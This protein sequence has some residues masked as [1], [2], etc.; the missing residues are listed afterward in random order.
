MGNYNAATMKL[1]R[2]APSAAVKQKRLATLLGGRSPDGEPR[3]WA[4]V[5][6]AQLLGSLQLAGFDF[7]WEQVLA[8]RR[9]E[10]VPAAL[11]DLRRAHAAVP[12]DAGFSLDA[13]RAWHAAAA[14]TPS[15]WRRAIRPRDPGPPPAPPAFIASRLELLASWLKA[16]SSRELG[17]A[18]AGAL[19][20]ARLIEIAPFDDANGRVARLAA[21]H[22]M[23][24]AGARPPVLVGADRPRLEAALQ[25]AFQLHTE[26]L[27]ALLEEASE[28]A[29][30]VMLQT[31]E[32]RA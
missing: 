16:D 21:S 15:A 14:G 4:A 23:V 11:A 27:T 5:E 10:R 13:L 12:R 30:D 22:M 8:S 32:G 20:M 1:L 17:A 6:D 2:L 19:V 28:R 29:L 18:Q 26:P 31:L 25:A 7:A 9:G 24:R 3:L